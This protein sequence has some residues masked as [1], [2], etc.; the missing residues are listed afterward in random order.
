MKE[1]SELFQSIRRKL[2]SIVCHLFEETR[3]KC[4][5]LPF[6]TAPG[7]GGPHS[8]GAKIPPTLSPAPMAKDLYVQKQWT[9]FVRHKSNQRVAFLNDQVQ[10]ISNNVQRMAVK[11]ILDVG[12]KR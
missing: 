5:R 3:Y 7:P 4:I 10:L 1:Y 9:R 8:P 6:P 12:G 11:K 2:A